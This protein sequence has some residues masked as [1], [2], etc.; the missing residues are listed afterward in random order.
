MQWGI[1]ADFSGLV[2]GVDEVGRGPLAG[3]VVAAAACL[4]SDSVPAGLGDSKKVPEKRREAIAA[5]LRHVAVA[6]ASVAEIDELNI[7]RASHLA[8]ARA[9]AALAAELGAPSMVLVDGN[10]LPGLAF[11]ARAI[12]KGD[13]TVACIAAAAIAAKVARDRQMRA[14]DRAFPGYGWASNKGYGSAAH[15]E[16]LQRLGP[17]PHHRRSFAPVKNY[18]PKIPG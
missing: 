2:F 12:V 7:L 5:G 11:P 18:F 1:E 13:A 14:L 8:M 15:L 6:E 9:V 10:L 3:P 4:F 16:A 17:T